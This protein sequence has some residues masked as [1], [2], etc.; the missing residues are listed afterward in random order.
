MGPIKGCDIM[1]EQVL[2]GRPFPTSLSPRREHVPPVTVSRLPPFFRACGKRS[3][4]SLFPRLA[5]GLLLRT[6]KARVVV[7]RRYFAD[8]PDSRPT[9]YWTSV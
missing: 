2:A 8:L 5:C 1:I 9:A 3:L 4:I 7:L 6:W